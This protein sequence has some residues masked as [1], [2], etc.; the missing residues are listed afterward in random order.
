MIVHRGQI[1]ARLLRDVT[2]RGG[3]KSVVGKQV[4]SG[5]EDPF[6]GVCCHG[7]TRCCCINNSNV[8][9]NHTFERVKSSTQ[10]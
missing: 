9:L 2:Q 7:S 4:F 8:H 10:S 6:F 1:D 3:R 5:V